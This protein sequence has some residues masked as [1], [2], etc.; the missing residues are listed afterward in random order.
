MRALATAVAVLSTLLAASGCGGSGA[1]PTAHYT[2]TPPTNGNAMSQPVAQRSS[3]SGAGP[4][5]VPISAKRRH[6]LEP[7]SLCRPFP[8]AD[9]SGNSGDCRQQNCPSVPDKLI[10]RSPHAIWVDLVTGSWSRTASGRRVE[11]PHSPGICLD[12]LHPVPVVIAIDPRQVDVHH[13][14]KVSLYYPKGAIRRYKRPVV[15][16]VPPL[17]TARV[18]EDVRVARAS[19]RLF[20][21]FPTVPSTARCA[22]PD[23]AIGTKPIPGTCET[24]IR[25]RRTM[26]PSWSVTFTETWPPCLSGYC[27]PP[28]R[29]RHHTWRVIEGETIVKP[30]TKPHVYAIHSR[31]ATAP[32]DYK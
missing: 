26:E 17:A 28:Y 27:P 31:G 18:R 24:T 12:D 10:V 13:Q 7:T 4:L 1:K 8:L 15:V 16:T 3:N 21:I 29:W 9:S 11:V 23:G 19:N 5:V 25:A 30:G 6:S 2:T 32:Q 14:L 22:I 20:S